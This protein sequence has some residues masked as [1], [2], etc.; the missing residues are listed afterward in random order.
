[1]VEEV[2]AGLTTGRVDQDME[3]LTPEQ[4]NAVFNL[5]NSEIHRAARAY[6]YSYYLVELNGEGGIEKDWIREVCWADGPGGRLVINIDDNEEV[7]DIKLPD[8]EYE[9]Y[10][11]FNDSFDHECRCGYDYDYC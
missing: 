1:M 8:V 9:D 10:T 7:F 6:Y 5:V 2:V 3:E 4:I 11:G